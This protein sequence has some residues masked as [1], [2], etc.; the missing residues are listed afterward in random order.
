MI[1]DNNPL[2]TGNY[3]PVHQEVTADNLTIIGEL[4]CELFGMYVRNGPNP[5]F[6]PIGDYHWFDGDGML[7]AVQLQNGKASYLNRYVQ[8]KGFQIE[9]KRGQAIWLGLLE[10][11]LW[12]NFLQRVWYRL[13]FK[14]VSNTSLVWHAGRLLSL[15]EAGKPYRISVP[16]LETVG[17]DT[18]DGQL[19]CAFTAHPKV[20]PVTGEMMFIGVSPVQKPY[21]QYGIVSSEGMI[22]QIMPIDLPNPVLIHDFAITENYTVFMDLP[23]LFDKKRMLRGKMPIRFAP[24]V[25]SRFGI[26]PRHGDQTAIRWFDVSLCYVFHVLNAYERGDEVIV[27]ACRM[28]ETHLLQPPI[29]EISNLYRWRFNMKSG[30]VQEEALDDTICDFPRLN[31]TRVGRPLQYGYTTEY[32]VQEQIITMHSLIKYDLINE[33][34]EIHPFGPNRYGGEAVFVP[35]PGSEVED[36]GWLLTYIHD[37][38]SNCSEL[39]VIEAQNMECEPLARV[40]LPQRVPYGFHGIWMEKADL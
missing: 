30:M 35:R 10:D 25:P 2:L 4:P 6:P 37:E 15:W 12:R 5:Q 9:R 36:D 3:A 19:T 22:Q 14:N 18:F 7:H 13:L 34:R 20:D 29:R 40:M 27:I 24:D 21:L 31:E 33:Q 26:M 11:K 23:L 17:P 16:D 1:N 39:L 38:D 28:A 32:M 8:T